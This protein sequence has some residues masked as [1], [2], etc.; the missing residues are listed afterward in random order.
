MTLCLN[1][2]VA[3]LSTEA[4]HKYILSFLIQEGETEK[5]ILQSTEFVFS[6]LKVLSDPPCN[7]YT[8]TVRTLWTWK[9]EF[10][11]PIRLYWLQ[12]PLYM[13]FAIWVQFYARLKTYVE[14]VT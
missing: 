2:T 10:F 9:F 8:Q 7:V 5:E 13:L 3:L 6:F 4:V 12:R 11:F 1:V 14:S